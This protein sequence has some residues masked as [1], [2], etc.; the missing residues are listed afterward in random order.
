MFETSGPAVGVT[1]ILEFYNDVEDLLSNSTEIKQ[2]TPVFKLL[3]LLDR[4]WIVSV[5]LSKGA[6]NK[7]MPVIW[8]Q[9]D[10]LVVHLF[11]L[12]EGKG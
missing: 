3:R 1:V 11:A 10:F 8:S 4:D 2:T 7:D 6:V 5:F 12:I 9:Y